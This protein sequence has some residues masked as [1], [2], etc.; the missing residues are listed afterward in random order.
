MGVSR[1]FVERCSAQTGFDA[2]TLEKV[3]RLGEIAAEVVRHPV[4]REALVMKGGRR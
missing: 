2:A 4:L 3:S 1:E